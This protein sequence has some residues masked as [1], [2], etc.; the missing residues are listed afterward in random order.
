MDL[1]VG[2]ACIKSS[3]GGGCT[4]LEAWLR[5]SIL[6]SSISSLREFLRLALRSGLTAAPATA[7]VTTCCFSVAAGLLAL[8]VLALALAMMRL[9]RRV[10][11]PTGA[12]DTLAAAV[13]VDLDDAGLVDFTAGAIASSSTGAV[14]VGGI[15]EAAAALF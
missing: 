15:T 1:D 12:S 13:A 11:A 8:V 14:A 9:L 3:G 10:T 4:F 7:A 6:W 2:V 5:A